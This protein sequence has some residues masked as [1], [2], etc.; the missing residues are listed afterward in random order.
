[1]IMS[2]IKKEAL[3]LPFVRGENQAAVV[4]DGEIHM[5]FEFEYQQDHSTLE[6]AIAYLESKGYSLSVLTSLMLKSK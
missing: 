6:R 4:T 2:K 5:S 3:F 1:M